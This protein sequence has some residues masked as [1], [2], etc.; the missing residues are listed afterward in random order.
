MATPIPGGSLDPHTVPKYVTPL[1]IPPQMPPTEGGP[2]DYY[3]IAVRQF[4]QQIL[5]AGMPPLCLALPH[6]RARGQRDDA[7]VL[8]WAEPANR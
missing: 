2:A 8:H 7:S 4:E 3:E 6:P 5:P 1:V